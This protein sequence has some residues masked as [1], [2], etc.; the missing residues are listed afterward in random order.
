MITF[1]DYYYEHHKIKIRNLQQPLLVSLPKEK[2]K[3]R[4]QDTPILLVPEL[5]LLTGT[6]LLKQFEKDFTMKKDL[7]AIT[8]LN[9]EVRIKRLRQFLDKITR[10]PEAKQDLENWQMEF[11]PDVV[12]VNATALVPITV[13]FQNTATTNTERGWNN[14][15]RDGIHLSAIPLRNWVLFYLPRDEQKANL[16][17][18]EL[19]SVSDPMGFRIERGQMCKLPDS[20]RGSSSVLFSSSIKEIVTSANPQMV[21]CIVPNT[22]KD[23]YDAIKVTCCIDF[24]VPSQVVTTNILNFNNMNKTKSAVTKIAIQMNCKLGGEPWGVT[25]PVNLKNL[26]QI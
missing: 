3:K 6:I 19:M 7:D 21:V 11:N 13:Q 14:A 15:M 22:N 17:M 23:T 1:A 8:K 25:I 20:G 4:G 24:G 9:P 2:D 26:Q 5:C 16:L 10:Q 18:T 12:K